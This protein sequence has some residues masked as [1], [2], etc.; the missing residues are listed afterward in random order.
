MTDTSLDTLERLL[1]QGLTTPPGEARRLVHGRGRCWPGL[2]AL[3]ADWLEGLLLVSLYR[4][5][6]EPWLAALRAR[7]VRL[8][9]DQGLAHLLLQHRYLRHTPCEALLGAPVE[10]WTL[11]ENGLRYR[12]D[13]GSKQNVGL[14]LDMREGRRWLRE[15][16][17]G[18]RVLNLF[19]YTCGFSVA[20]MAGGARSV[21]NLD[22]SRPAL[23][24]GRENHR[25]NGHDLD[26]VAFFAHDILKSWGKLGRLGPYDLIVVDPPSSQKGSFHAPRDYPKVIRHLPALLAPGGQVLACLNDPEQG[27]ALV[28]DAVAREAPTLRFVER[29]DNP[30]E[31]VDHDPGRALKVLVFAAP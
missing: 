17:A 20:A 16:A 26:R 24:R 18:Q 4:P 29:L 10:H 15:R 14:F 13:L 12:L 19:A 28:L 5:M 8:G 25:L 3:T 27:P 31:F 21:L 23:N 2:E 11:H 7:L 1:Q 9:Q 22:L 30:P 6:D